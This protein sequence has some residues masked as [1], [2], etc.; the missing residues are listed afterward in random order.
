MPVAKVLAIVQILILLLPLQ[1]LYYFN[2]SPKHNTTLYKF[3]QVMAIFSK[4]K[5]QVS[6]LLRTGPNSAQLVVAILCVA[7]KL[8]SSGEGIIR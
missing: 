7:L 3:L 5:L 2:H 4:T 6:P 1:A 8:Q